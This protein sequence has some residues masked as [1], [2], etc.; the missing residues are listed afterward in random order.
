MN[1]KYI[2]DKKNIALIKKE[3]TKAENI[4]L[5]LDY[6]GTLAPFKND[7]L[8]AFVLPEIKTSLEKLE[9]SSKY[10][11]SLVSG[12]K[13][14]ELKKMIDLSYSNYAGSHGLEIDMFFKKEVIYP[15]QNQKIDVLSKKNYQK[16]KEKFLQ[17]ESVELEDKGFGFALHFK[18]ELKK[19]EAKKELKVLFE[20]TAYQVLSGRKIIEIRPKGWDKG[21]A[22]NYIT[23][24]IKANL[25]LANGLR[26]YIGDD[27]TDEDAFK[28][29]K[30]GITIYV[31]NENDLNTEAEFYLKDPADTAELL[32]KLAGSF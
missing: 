18:S 25:D 9:K 4:L 7:P 10:Y 28:V 12:R 23:D 30:D 16:V 19:K 27:T 24:Q 15:Y 17:A 5:F 13:L 22:V 8:S 3:I 6:D 21:K 14:N 29:V 31:Q 20:N 11:L 26:I 32:K 2:F 1:K